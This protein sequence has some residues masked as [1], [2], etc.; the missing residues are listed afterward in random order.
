MF[1]E[2]PN[3]APGPA[4]AAV[5]ANADPVV[6]SDADLLDVVTGWERLARWASAGVL[7]GLAEFS[8]R[9]TGAAAEFAVDE[10]ALALGVTRVGADRRLQL[11]EGLRRLLDT[12]DAVRCGRIDTYKAQIIVDAVTPLSDEAAAAVE[13][14]VLPRAEGQTPGQLRAACARAVLIADPAGA[15]QRY[16]EAKKG[17]QIRVIPLSEGMAE[18]SLRHT[19]DRI[20]AL[21]NAVDTLARHASTADAIIRDGEA[22]GGSSDELDAGTLDQ[23]RA[24]AMID[25][26]GLA[27]DDAR[28]F[29]GPT[30][31]AQAADRE[32]PKDVPQPPVAD[33]WPTEEPPTH[34]ATP[35][36]SAAGGEPAEEND[37]PT[38]GASRSDN[39]GSTSASGSSASEG[40]S[41]A[42]ESAPYPRALVRPAAVRDLAGQR[43]DVLVQVIIPIG[44][45]LGLT[46]QPGELPGYGPIPP[47]LAREI[48]AD[49]TWQRIFT[50]PVTGRLVHVDRGAYSPPR[51]IAEHVRTR[52]RTCRFPGCRRSAAR[53]D[54]DHTI[55]HPGGPTC[56]CNLACLCRHHHRLKQH[57]EW[58]LERTP[59]D[60]F[61]WTTPTGNRYLTEPPP[62]LDAPEFL[63]A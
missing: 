27:L 28:L 54:L 11:A 56:V 60:V 49:A 40:G 42:S 4:T 7:A 29:G 15:A 6:L 1:E 12:L 44:T 48:A 21:F 16:E 23:R 43:R 19:A 58:R 39:A 24:D 2:C 17:R 34:S 37:Q 25:L 35:D 31:S 20:A 59:D 61:A 45:L 33:D 57:P 13:A 18:L 30:A 52:D 5:L 46:D 63:T 32:G 53:C 3:Q 51:A 62:L 22:A 47:D 38:Q 14:R 36:G 26:A 41:N 9:R 8:G 50:D 10:V 55:A